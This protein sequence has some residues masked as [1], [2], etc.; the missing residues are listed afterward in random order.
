[1][2]L[3][4]VFAPSMQTA[5][6]GVAPADAGVASALVNT[7]QQVG[8]SV[9]VA[10]LSTIAGSAATG[11]LHGRIPTPELMAQATMHSYTTTFWVASAIFAGGA[12]LVGPLLRPG[13]PA[14]RPAGSP[15]VAPAFAH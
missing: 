10:L 6:S 12:L 13:T 7:S 4:L 8:G 15:A 2:G 3:G 11:Y 14:V 1:M 5:V 9:G